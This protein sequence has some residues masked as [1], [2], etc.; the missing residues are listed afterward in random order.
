MMMVF[1]ITIEDT[2]DNHGGGCASIL[3]KKSFP[4]L[5]ISKVI[6]FGKL[7]DEIHSDDDD[8]TPIMRPI[9]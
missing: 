5:I 4:L 8:D 9:P 3:G 2:W 7:Y 1:N 6:E